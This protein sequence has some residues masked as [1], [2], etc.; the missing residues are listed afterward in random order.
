MK[1]QFVAVDSL[2][3]L[4]ATWFCLFYFNAQEPTYASWLCSF[5]APKVNSFLYFHY[6]KLEL[7]LEAHERGASLDL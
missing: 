4:I 6:C 7:T 1:E 2:M 5:V 3:L